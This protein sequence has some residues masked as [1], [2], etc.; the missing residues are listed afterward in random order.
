MADGVENKLKSHLGM[1]LR[2]IVAL[3]AISL[4]FIKHKPRQLYSEL[5]R[6]DWWVFASAMALYWIA[7]VVFVLRWRLLSSV[8][9]VHF[10]FWAG[11]RL[12]FLGL[13]YNNCLPSSIGG[14]I[15]RAWYV[16]H[17]CDEDKKEEAA[18]SVFVDRAVGL[19]GLFI[20]AGAFYWLVPVGVGSLPSGQAQPEG[21][22]SSFVLENA[23]T[24]LSVF[25]VIVLL[26]SGIFL[27][28]RWRQ[29]IVLIVKK[30]VNLGLRLFFKGIK[31]FKLYAKQPLV[32]V[33]ALGL[34][35]LC[36]GLCIIGFYLCGLNLGINVH[37]KYYF[38]LFPVSWLI[39]SLPI[40]IGGVGFMEVYL[41]EAFSNLMGGTKSVASA[42]LATCQRLAFVLGS[43][44]GLW[45]HLSGRHLPDREEILVDSETSLD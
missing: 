32:L 24:I 40:S 38:V 5:S 12:H 42:A 45:V 7:Q 23:G 39:G 13:F 27:V 30:V 14:D 37:F 41:A 1:I 10:G 35:F 6:L 15:I 18:L 3:G 26:L 28:K 16:T 36:Q 43:L 19:L 4:F 20:M 17:H 21:D 25:A 2:I 22:K 8:Q 34:T 33:Y 31:A 29:K 9:S 44:P 11:L